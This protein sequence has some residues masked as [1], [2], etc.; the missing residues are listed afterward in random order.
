MA[1]LTAANWVA[2]TVA[3]TVEMTVEKRAAKLVENSAVSWV[4]K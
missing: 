2:S 1:G 4:E 3:S